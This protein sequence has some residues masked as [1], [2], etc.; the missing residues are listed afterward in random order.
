MFR[1]TS[2]P[3][4]RSIAALACLSWLAYTAVAQQPVQDPEKR[5]L[6]LRV[7]QSET[8]KGD[9][10]HMLERRLV[11]VLVPYS[12]TEVPTMDRQCDAPL[13]NGRLQ[14]TVRR[15]ARR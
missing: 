7:V 5:A 1:R 12:R 4:L 9:F 6:D 10:E 8:W 3:R 14:R 13:P 15:A 11:R 2:V